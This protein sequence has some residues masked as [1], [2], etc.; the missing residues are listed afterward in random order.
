MKG[1]RIVGAFA[2]ALCFLMSSL[3][4]AQT[5]TARIVGTVS[6]TSGAVIPGV[7]V[8]V[9]S[10][11]TGAE[12]S[13]F[14]ND[15]GAFVVTP[16]AAAAYTVKADQPGFSRREYSGIIVQVGQEKNVNIV[17]QPA[18]IAQE[19]TVSAGE[20]TQVDTS[21]AR[22]GVNVSERE[23]SQLPLNGRQVSQLYLMSPGAV[24]SGS[25]T[26]DNIR[27][28]GRS[29]QQNVIRFDGVEGSSIVDSSPGNL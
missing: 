2:T 27:F 15:K 6:D 26:F 1:R 21:S 5:D 11:K 19:V 12:R 23:V 3:A 25:G 13:V 10:E 18:G 17:L 4:W 22:V 20:L 24:N 7:T 14:T 28:S 29:N 8:S 9:K 16:L